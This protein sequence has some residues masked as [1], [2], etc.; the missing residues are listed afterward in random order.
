ML[1]VHRALSNH[2]AAVIPLVYVCFASQQ[3][4][5]ESE[6]IAAVLEAYSLEDQL[7]AAPGQYT[8]WDDVYRHYRQG[9]SEEI[10]GNLA[11]YSWRQ[12][13]GVLRETEKVMQ[14]PGGVVVL[15][16]SDT[17][18]VVAYPTTDV[19]LELWGAGK[20]TL[21]RLQLE[22]DHWV[23]VE[24]NTTDEW[25]SGYSTR[26]PNTIKECPVKSRQ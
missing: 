5:L 4:P 20:F 24:S 9:F 25:P 13:G 2:L 15:E 14:V 1:I 19:M 8:S 21:D 12:E 17:H 3:T 18:A 6:I 26:P 22:D 11:D 7:Y 16:L 10:A 23:I